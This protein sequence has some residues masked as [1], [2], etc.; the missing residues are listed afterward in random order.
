M[1]FI[2]KN[3]SSDQ[4]CRLTNITRRGNISAS[5]SVNVRCKLLFNCIMFFKLTNE[6]VYNR[7]RVSAVI[8]IY[9]IIIQRTD[10]HG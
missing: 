9:D 8:T 7:M 6:I 4:R 1:K 10:C 3:I 5:K 2:I